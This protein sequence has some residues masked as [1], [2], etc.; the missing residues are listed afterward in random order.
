MLDKLDVDHD[1]FVPLDEIVALAEGEGLGIVI[2]EE[3]EAEL[4]KIQG[5]V[6]EAV[7]SLRR[8]GRPV[9]NEGVVDEAKKEKKDEAAAKKKEEPKL[10]KEDVVE[11]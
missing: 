7:D 4:D 11:S 1:N 6:N 2:S 9:T 8:E 5:D 10:K 3:G